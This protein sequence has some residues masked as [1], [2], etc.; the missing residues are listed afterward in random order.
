MSFE[1]DRINELLDRNSELA[2]EILLNESLVY[3]AETEIDSIDKD[4]MG[5]STI[6][7]Y[8]G[9]VTQLVERLKAK[10]NLY[11]KEIFKNDLEIKK[12]NN[13]E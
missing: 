10:N 3:E 12:L 7:Q 6:Q 5:H 13:N 2:K 1:F 9:Q 11:K 8:L 4:I